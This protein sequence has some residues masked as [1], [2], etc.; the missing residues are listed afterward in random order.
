[1]RMPGALAKAPNSPADRAGRRRRA[2]QK[3]AEI[4][5]ADPAPLRWLSFTTPSTWSQGTTMPHH[6]AGLRQVRHTRPG[7]H[8]HDFVITWVHGINPDP[9]LR[10]ECGSQKPPAILHPRCGAHDRNGARVEHLVDRHHLWF[11][12]ELHDTPEKPAPAQ[13]GERGPPSVGHTRVGKMTRGGLYPHLERQ[14]RMKPKAA[15]RGPS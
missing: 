8:P 14:E 12:P 5:I 7:L 3:P 2:R 11:C 4:T 6:V 1:M 9:V 10:L 13:A 15:G